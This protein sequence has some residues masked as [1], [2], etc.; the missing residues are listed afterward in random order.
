MKLLSIFL[1]IIFL[2]SGS[3][4]GSVWCN[5]IECAYGECPNASSASV[6]GS[7]QGGDQIGALVILGAGHFLK[8]HSEIQLFLNKFELSGLYGANY[9]EMKPILDNAISSMESA[10]DTYY[11][12]K[13]IA[14]ATRYNQSVIKNLMNFDYDFFLDGRNLNPLVFQEVKGY[15]CDGNVNGVISDIYSK[16]FDILPLLYKIKLCIDNN[17]LPDVSFL[18]ELNQEYSNALLFGQYVAWIFKSII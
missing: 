3:L 10:K 7:I 14:S 18:W 13:I 1:I 17:T 8:S 9:D 16:T 15:L 5:W 11:N 12:L 2:F 4:F 6:N